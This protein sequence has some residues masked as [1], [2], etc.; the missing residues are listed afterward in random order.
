MK[1][2]FGNMLIVLIALVI[3]LASLG[4]GYGLWSRTLTLEGTI[5]T[6]NIQLAWVDDPLGSPPT[7][8]TND[9]DKV[10]D[11]NIDGGSAP[12]QPPDDGH[13][14]LSIQ[15]PYNDDHDTNWVGLPLVDEDPIDG[16]DNDGDGLTDEDPP[17]K[18]TSCDPRSPVQ[19]L[20]AGMNDDGD[21]LTD[22]D[23]VDG[24][25]NDGDSAVDEDGASEWRVRYDQ[26]VRGSDIGSTIT[27]VGPVD[28]LNI[29]ALAA[30]FTLTG[31]YS[32][33]TYAQAINM[34]S[35]PVAVVAITTTIPYELWD[36]DGNGT[37][38]DAND[39]GNCDHPTGEGAD[40]CAPAVIAKFT[41]LEVGDIMDPGVPIDCEL[42]ITMT[43]ASSPAKAY[44]VSVGITGYN[45]NEAP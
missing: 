29:D 38:T 21:L 3:G 20:Y 15:G 32:P 25:D 8:F 6:G 11:P 4:V 17:G 43:P 36:V 22:E 13:C 37:T 45:Y 26:T 30:S 34:G 35:V 24:V 33:T 2:R 44:S 23:P 31:G 18:L 41:G 14:P 9:D 27:Y 5:D 42:R 7:P 28:T 1:R 19:W 39:D 12:L 16:V 10:D 40:E